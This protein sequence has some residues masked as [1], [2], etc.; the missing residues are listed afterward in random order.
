M[1]FHHR[2]NGLPLSAVSFLPDPVFPPRWD[3]TSLRPCAGFSRWASQMVDTDFRLD[4]AA[5]DIGSSSLCWNGH[6]ASIRVDNA[7]AGPRNY[8][9]YT[10]QPGRDEATRTGPSGGSFAFDEQSGQSLI[11]TGNDLFDGLFALAYHEM[12]LLSV[13]GVRRPPLDVAMRD[14]GDNDGNWIRCPSSGDGGCFQTGLRW[15]SIWTRDIAYSVELALAQLD[16]IRAMNSL[17]FKVSPRR[18]AEPGVDSTEIVQDTGTGGSWPVSTDRV[19]WARG[20]WELLKYL[21]GDTRQ[22]FAVQAYTALMNTIEIDREAAY[23]P[24]DGLYRGEASFLD[25]REQ[26][27]P[28]WTAHDVVHIGMSKALSTNVNHWKILDVAS[29]MAGELGRP[30]VARYRTWAAQLKSAINDHFWLANAGLYSMATLTGLEPS[31]TERYELLGQAL[32]I[33]DGIADGPKA[34]SILSHYP[35]TVGGAPVQW[36]QTRDLPCYHSAAI[37]PFVSAYLVKAAS[38]GTNDAVVNR[39]VFAMMRGAALSLSHMENYEFLRLENRPLVV[40]SEAQLWSVAGYL[41]LVLDVTFGRQTSQTGIRFL[42]FVTRLMRNQLFAATNLLKLENLPYKGTILNVTVKLPGADGHVSG[43]YRVRRVSLNGVE[44]AVEREMTPS[45]LGPTNEI[46][47][48]LTHTPAANKGL[49]LVR[50]PGDWRRFWAPFE[51]A[52]DASTGVTRTDGK[53]TLHW[54]PQGETGTVFDVY[55]NGKRVASGVSETRWLDPESNDFDSAALCYAVTQRYSGDFPVQNVS[56]PSRPVYFGGAQESI[57]AGDSRFSTND[58]TEALTEHGRICYSNWG[59]EHQTIDVAFTPR[60]SGTYALRLLYGNAF[61][62]VQQGITNCVKQVEIFGAHD[63]SIAKGVVMMP[64]RDSWGDWGESSCLAAALTAGMT[65]RI[66]ISDHHNMSY[67][68]F[69]AAYNGPGG[70]QA[71]NRANIE[72]VRLRLMPM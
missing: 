3:W 52:V 23:D 45:E 39:N 51:P 16:P 20:A 5:G 32:A 29:Q 64:Q 55:R 38:L 62:S 42:P 70:K 13:D 48:E 24:R 53:L 6:T 17:L 2:D 71:I 10:D 1:E 22:E 37:W 9:L 41:N 31:A 28:S 69:N 36:P 27:Y 46:V 11:R 15:P 60:E 72:G 8:V 50:D 67:L 56:H 25:W 18:R 7:P 66:H 65:Y 40:N 68:A 12:R 49:T 54:D 63:L 30:E 19:V 26:T 35:H 34:T 14:V 4:I 59:Y 58:G 47:I 44:R 61:N 57:D 43:H 33:L 21:T